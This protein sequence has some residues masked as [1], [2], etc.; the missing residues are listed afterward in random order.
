[1]HVPGSRELL[2]TLDPRRSLRARLS[3]IFGA[4]SLLLA[5]LLGLVVDR[6]TEERFRQDHGRTLAHSALRTADRLD[7]DLFERYR[8][9]QTLATHDH[10]PN[11]ETLAPDRRI[12][13]ETFQRLYPG[14]AWI[15]LAGPSGRVLVSTNG[16]LEGADVS[17]QPWFQAARAGPYVGDGMQAS[18]PVAGS[19]NPNG[20]SS[21]FVDIA[22]P[23]TDEQGR[24]HGV[25]GAYLSWDWAREV[26][27]SG[28]APMDA[29][30]Q[31]DVFIAGPEGR[32]LQIHPAIRA[33]TDTLE[34]ESLAKAQN[35]ENDYLVETWSDDGPRYLTGY[36]RSDGYRDFSGMG[37]VVLVRQDTRIAFAPAQEL[38]AQVLSIRVVVS[39]A[40]AAL[41]WVLAGWLTQ[42]LVA[43]TAASD[44]ILQGD[45]ATRIPAVRGHDELTRLAASLANLVGDLTRKEAELQALNADLAASEQRH[46]ALIEHSADVIALITADG[47]IRY[48]SPAVARIV[49]YQP[50]ELVGRSA[51]ALVHPDDHTAATGL[52]KQC[53]QQPGT[54]ITGQ[55][56]YE[57]KDG[58]WRWI[59]ATSTNLLEA[60]GVQAIV[61]N[62]RDITPRRQAEEALRES[63]TRLRL[64]QQYA[65]LGYI[66]VDANMREVFWSDET[67]R[68]LGYEPQA[69]TPAQHHF[70]EHVHPEDAEMIRREI[71]QLLT[72]GRNSQ[73]EYRIVRPDG[74]VRWIYGRSEAL[75]DEQGQP[76][77][78]IGIL[79]DITERKRAE[80]EIRQLNAE[81]EQRI[82]ERT[83][84]LEVANRELEAF[85]YSVSHDLR[86]PLRAIDGY[87]RILVEDYE[88]A[89]DAEGRRVCA[90]IRNET[91]RMSQLIDDLLTFSRLSRARIQVAPIDMT[92]LV[93]SVFDDLALNAN[94]ERIDFRVA[95]LPKTVGDPAL[96]R[97]VWLNLLSNALKFSSKKERAIIEVAGKQ[98]DDRTIYWVRDNGAG[99]DTQYI[100]KLFSVFQRLH[101]EREFEGT[102]VG[103][104]IV[105]RIIQRHGGHVWAE[106]ELDQGATFYFTL[107]QRR[108]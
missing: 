104:A 53:L 14:Y 73:S 94:R 41:G 25:L 77:R 8:D 29:Q 42:P 97:Q 56:R 2:A 70:F 59:E 43:I 51:C 22:V 75:L 83:A 38:K 54:P 107:P 4:L 57:H 24:L 108:D 37:W 72:Q 87:T 91:R 103:L 64:A 79:L 55:I 102:G 61:M 31:V 34:L 86:A 78:F 45:R 47:I 99:F 92:R 5:L 62:Y 106:S 100:E 63:D 84:Q 89:L 95:P 52:F 26:V 105:Q 32:I 36:A 6:M 9:M 96:I 40:F 46:R 33:V 28:I 11:P 82:A 19:S 18:L 1:M 44:R 58:T 80:A 30:R 90:V 88:A 98:A 69:F 67:F 23:V 16:L 50:E 65:Q 17:Q 74:E 66:D 81:L 20:V 93:A 21:R 3:L 39:G 76:R 101:S 13:L 35:D 71:E 48:N 12:L 27:A 85:A 68:V 49:G 10:L 15:G 7:Q 60:P